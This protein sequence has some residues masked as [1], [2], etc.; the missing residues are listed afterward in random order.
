MFIVQYA[1]ARLDGW[2]PSVSTYYP[3]QQVKHSLLVQAVLTIYASF[4]MNVSPLPL[5]RTHCPVGDSDL[6]DPCFTA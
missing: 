2:R 6:L 5:Y 3:R 1:N 4:Q